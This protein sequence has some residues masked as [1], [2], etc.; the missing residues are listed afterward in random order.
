MA[1][2]G[3]ENQDYKLATFLAQGLSPN[4]AAKRLGCPMRTARRR[5]ATEGVKKLVASIR[6]QW[7]AR[8]TAKLSRG[9]MRATKR[10]EAL[11]DS[12]NPLVA[13]GA[14]RS[15]L[16]FGLKFRDSLDFAARLEAIEA[17]LNDQNAEGANVEGA[18]S[19]DDQPG[20]DPSG[21]GAMGG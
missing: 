8:T 2:S 13:L 9:A 1:Q 11:M 12:P 3:R 4:Q 16:E 18:T 10:L 19:D 17:R 15:F 6:Q 14:T 5:A 21:P 20:E 7:L